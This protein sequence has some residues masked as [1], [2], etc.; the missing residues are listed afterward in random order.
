LYLEKSAR[1][2]GGQWVKV[3]RTEVR[4]RVSRVLHLR[5]SLS[6]RATLQTHP[7]DEDGSEPRLGLAGGR[8]GGQVRASPCTWREGDI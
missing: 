4:R 8:G 3:E 1:P 6:G 7:R 2:Q 5:D